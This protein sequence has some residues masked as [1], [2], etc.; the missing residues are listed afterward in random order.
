[1]VVKYYEKE[2]HLLAVGYS[3]KLIT[4]KKKKFSLKTLILVFQFWVAQ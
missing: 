2:R 4:E 1:M 3:M